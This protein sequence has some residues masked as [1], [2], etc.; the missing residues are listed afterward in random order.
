M[1]CSSSKLDDLPAVALCRERCTFLDDA[2]AQRYALAESHVAY[3]HSLKLIGQS[4]EQFFDQDLVDNNYASIPSPILNL[5]PHKKGDPIQPAIPISSKV[6]DNNNNNNKSHTHSHSH[7]H[8]GSHLHFHSDS[9]SDGD[10]DGSLHHSG[11]SSPLHFQNE[12]FQNENRYQNYQDDQGENFGNFMNM[13]YMRNRSTPSV[14]HEQRPISP[15][16]MQMNGGSTSSYYQNQE[17]LNNPYPYYNQPNN[18]PPPQYSSFYG[19]GSPTYGSAYP[20]PPQASAASSSKPPPPPPSPPRASAWDFLNPFE[21]FEKYYPQNTP[22]RDSRSVREEEGIPDLEDESFQD[23]VVKEVHGEQRFSEGGG[24]YSKKLAEDEEEEEEEVKANDGE[25]F[26]ET[27]EASGSGKNDGM[28]YEV[29]LVDKNVVGNEDRSEEK[30]NVTAFKAKVGSRGVSV[31]IREIKSQFDRAS[32]SGNEVSM[33]LEVGKVPFHPKNAV[34]QVSSKMLHSITPSLS[35]VSSHPSTSKSAETSTK[36]ASVYLDLGQNVGMRS[37]NLSS[38]LQTLY[39]WEKKLYNEVKAEEKMR[40]VHERK[41][42]RLKRLDEKGAEATKIDATRTLV[43][44]LS[45]KIKIAIQVVDKI[46]DKINKLRDEELWP[47]INELI[48]GLIGMWKV[49]LECHRNQCQAIA[50]A[51]NLDAITSN[52]NLDATMKLE[53]ELL[54]WIS[55]FTCWIGAQKGYV[56]ALN[57]WL[58]KCLFYEPEETADGIVPFS[59]GRIGA[60]PVFVICNQWSQAMERISEK[61][62]IDAMRVFT[63]SVHQLSE[64]HN[65]EFRQRMLPNKDMEGKVKLLEKKEQKMQK[66]WQVIDKKMA[67]VSGQGIG[68]PMPGEIVHQSDTANINSLHLGL[69]QIFDAMEKFTASS[70]QAYEELQLRCEEDRLARENAKVP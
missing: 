36:A 18:Y 31:V 58:L 60:P 3:I 22:S 34:Y 69:K 32:E 42:R 51:K 48:K 70:M 47:Q 33:M 49:M 25:G 8:S 28:E 29:H 52:K 15:E 46:S 30:I 1:G 2:I 50:E 53:H 19:S 40:I 62:V 65:Q 23:E 54:N 44:T 38:T 21:A 11:N 57:G 17:N 63:W 27:K 39:I 5:P 9:D 12:H 67:M 41:V 10:E 24:K 13:N 59:P 6:V 55:S 56:R 61:D 64:R 4:L 37:G 43:R 45:T 26:Y 68:L 66:E 14:V 7:S 35:V 16:I 20:P